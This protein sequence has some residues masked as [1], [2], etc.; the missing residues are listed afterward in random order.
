MKSRCAVCMYVPVY[1]FGILSAVFFFLF[2]LLS[3]FS[4]HCCE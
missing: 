2:L 3:L 4:A 1:V